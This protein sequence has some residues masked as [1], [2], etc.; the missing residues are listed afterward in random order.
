[1]Q[2]AALPNGDKGNETDLT[3]S[4]PIVYDFLTEIS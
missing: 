2:T 3:F 1:M 4:H